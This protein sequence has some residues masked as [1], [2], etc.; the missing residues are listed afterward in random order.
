MHG[1][2]MCMYRPVTVMGPG[3]GTA[4]S[5]YMID[6]AAVVDFAGLAGCNTYWSFSICSPLKKYMIEHFKI[7]RQRYS[8]KGRE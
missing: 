2:G 7:V 4:V 8:G 1:A 3:S 6:D 5:N